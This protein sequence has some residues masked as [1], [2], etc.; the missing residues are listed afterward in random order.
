MI[1]TYQLLLF[2][3]KQGE[4]RKKEILLM[5][6]VQ[7]IK[8]RSH[9]SLKDHSPLWSSENKALQFNPPNIALLSIWSSRDKISQFSPWNIF[10]QSK[11]SPREV[12][13]LPFRNNFDWRKRFDRLN[14][15]I[16]IG[17]PNWES[18]ILERL[19]HYLTPLIWTHMHKNECVL[20]C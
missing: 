11:R 7:K 8:Y 6:L 19:N 17:G 14:W 15:E 4:L 20:T 18:V 10:P 12:F 9:R 16:I 1:T 5:H 13:W 2:S 3:T